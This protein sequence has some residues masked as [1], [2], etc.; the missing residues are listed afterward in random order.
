MRSS[1]WL[2]GQRSA[3]QLN[4]LEGNPSVMRSAVVNEL[5]GVNPVQRGRDYAD[6]SASGGLVRLWRIGAD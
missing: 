3:P 2:F 4:T 1:Y 5:H 6:L